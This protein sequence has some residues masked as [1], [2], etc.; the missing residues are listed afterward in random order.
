MRSV[1]AGIWKYVSDEDVGSS[2][3]GGSAFCQ[4]RGR[5]ARRR[6][7][8]DVINSARVK[9]M[10]CMRP[11]VGSPLSIVVAGSGVDCHQGCSSSRGK[12]S[13]GK[14]DGYVDNTFCWLVWG[15]ESWW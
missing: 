13:S 3:G 12:S 9:T 2:G 7:T 11:D 6:R 1:G 8:I 15:K 10:A 5:R 4:S 14:G